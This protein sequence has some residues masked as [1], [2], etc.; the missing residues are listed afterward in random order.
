MLRRT[1]SPPGVR[2]AFT[3]IELLVVIAIVAILIGL[4]LPAI[5]KVRAA[6]ARSQC[7]NNLHQLG[8]ALH[9]HHSS[10]NK[11]PPARGDYLLTLAI[12]LGYGP[13]NNPPY[14]GFYPGSF[15]QPGGWMV[16]VLP[17]IEQG[18]LRQLLD[19]SGTA[20]FGP[21]FDN[22]NKP[23]KTFLC[24]ADPRDLMVVKPGDGA[25]T[26][27]VAVSGGGD[28]F[29]N[30]APPLPGV[31]DQV[32]GPTSGIFDVKS[33]GVSVNL[34][35]DGTSNTLMIGERPPAADTLWGWAFS[36]DFDN[37]I[38]VDMRYSFYPP[39]EP[40]AQP[41]CPGIPGR[42]V[43]G[44]PKFNCHMNHFYSMHATGANWLFGDGSVRFLPYSA[45][46]ILIPMATRAANDVYDAL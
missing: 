20:W 25:Y 21:F 11:F 24:P 23:V 5:Q 22:Y 42:Y 12:A 14:G 7:Q 18:P 45:Q 10:Y 38:P 46:A 6:A 32:Y 28:P 13:G 17:Y 35:M 34:I 4:L 8:T 1:Q 26:G 16:N 36:S 27:Y 37:V 39:T 15:V 43:P 41:V 44:N 30:F 3:L 31:Y 29:N 9:N 40:G 2:S 19:Y 33:E